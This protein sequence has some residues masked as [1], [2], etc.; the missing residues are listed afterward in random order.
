[1]RRRR[2]G[3]G[4]CELTLKRAIALALL[5][6][7]SGCSPPPVGRRTT[8]SSAAGASAVSH[9]D[10]AAGEGSSEQPQTVT[11]GWCE[12]QPILVA[13]CGRCHG[14][15]LANGAPFT[16]VS[17]ADTQQ[18]DSRGRPRYDRMYSA[19]DTGF[20]PATFVKLD[21]PVEA[22]SDTERQQLLDWLAAD[23]PSGDTSACP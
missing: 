21:P 10:G 2:W 23:A 17:H 16:L 1:M 15:P 11:F 5:V 6:V 20:M 14:E 12:A 22:L 13:K 3:T 7:V 18:T 9:H 4:R 19:I 8:K